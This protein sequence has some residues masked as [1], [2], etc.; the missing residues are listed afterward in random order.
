MLRRSLFGRRALRALID[1]GTVSAEQRIAKRSCATGHQRSSVTADKSGFMGRK[2]QAWRVW[3]QYGWAFL[4]TYFGI[5]GLSLIVVYEA[6]EHGLITPASV[7]WM[8]RPESDAERR[9]L[10]ENKYKLLATRAGLGSVIDLSALDNVSPH[11]GSFIVAF[12]V[13]GLTEPMRLVLSVAATPRIAAL[14]R[15]FRV[16]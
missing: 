15:S 10:A 12:A 6:V 7:D 9:L 3:E 5:Y 4:G 13:A 2:Q 8:C 11:T 16:K 14:A 1:P